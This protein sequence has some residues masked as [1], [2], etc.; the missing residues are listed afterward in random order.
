MPIKTM[1]RIAGA[2]AILGAS[3][4]L[5]PV[6]GHASAIGQSPLAFTD[7]AGRQV[8]LA[9]PPRRIVVIGDGPY[10]LAH[11]LYMF[12]EGRARMI[13]MERKGRTASEFLPLVDPEFAKKTFLDPNP[14]PEQIAGLHPDLVLTRGSV[15]DPKAES[16]AA[17]GI[18][19]AQLGLETPAEY[20]RDLKTLGL[21]L[22]NPK[23]AEEIAAYYRGR[24]TAVESGLAGL[25]D[26]AKPRVL[27]AMAIA[28]AG[29]VAVQVPA[30]SWMQTLQV[31]AGGGLPVWLDSAHPATGWTVINLEQIAAWNPDQIYIVFWHSMDPGKA[32]EDFKADSRWAALKAVRVGRLMAFPADI[33]GWDTPDPRW[34]LGLTWLA[35]RIH[36]DKFPSYDAGAE[37]DLFYGTLYG[38]NHAEVEAKIKP[39]VKTDLR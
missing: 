39:A 32:L 5:L 23:R 26:A 1:R 9:G 29:K 13:A 15:P 34:I 37:M 30:R 36:P 38:M 20:E 18:P 33:Y 16:L 8:K 28:R 11:L 6:A 25:A 24:R 10:I 31:Q 7:A 21:L 14:G 35:A 12:P 2:A 22:D 17:I 4:A 27:L 19:V 3:L